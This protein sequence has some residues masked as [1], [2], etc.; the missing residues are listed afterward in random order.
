MFT[1][2]PNF[3]ARVTELPRTPAFHPVTPL[4]LCYQQPAFRIQTFCHLVRLY[5]WL[6]VMRF[7]SFCQILCVFCQL[8]LLFLFLALSIVTQIFT[9]GTVGHS[10]HI[11]LDSLV[12]Y[13]QLVKRKNVGANL[14]IFKFFFSLQDCPNF[15][16]HKSWMHIASDGWGFINKWSTIGLNETF[17]IENFDGR[18][19]GLFVAFPDHDKD[20]AQFSGV[21]F[22]Y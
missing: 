6:N 12:F 10:T 16:I 7:L 9:L 15:L 19:F 11:T 22:L 2:P 4:L 5:I 14:F 8:N 20:V 13:T 1:V 18:V 3:L 17:A 21:Y